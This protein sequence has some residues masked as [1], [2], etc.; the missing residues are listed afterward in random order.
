MGNMPILK[1]EERQSEFIIFNHCF[2]KVVSTLLQEKIFIDQGFNSCLARNFMKVGREEL[3]NVI[4]R[5]VI[6][7][8][9]RFIELG[10]KLGYLRSGKNGNYIFYSSGDPVCYIS[11]T[12]VE[13]IKS[14]GEVC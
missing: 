14:K 12:V 8:K 6:M 7:A 10:L 9:G 3:E 13:I 2:H 5:D 11:R 1:D 4:D